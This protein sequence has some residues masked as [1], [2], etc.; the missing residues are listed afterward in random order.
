MKELTFITLNLNCHYRRTFPQNYFFVYLASCHKKIAD[1]QCFPFTLGDPSGNELIKITQKR[2]AAAGI[3]CGAV[4][5]PRFIEKSNALDVD[6]RGARSQVIHVVLA[7]R[8]IWPGFES[9]TR[10]H[11]WIDLS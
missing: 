4:L 9:W 1:D 7:F 3:R 8:V 2:G 6:E 10:C 5:G 11:A